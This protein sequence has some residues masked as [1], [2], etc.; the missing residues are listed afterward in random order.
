MYEELYIHTQYDGKDYMSVE[1]ISYF[2][3]NG[4]TVICVE[5]TDAC[6]D[7]VTCADQGSDLWGWIKSQV[8]CRLEQAGI[9]YNYIYFEDERGN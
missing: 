6:S 3:E 1:S 4:N 2:D 8:E 5:G 9:G 7:I